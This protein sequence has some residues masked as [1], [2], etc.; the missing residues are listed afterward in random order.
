[1]VS[2]ELFFTNNVAFRND[3][4]EVLGAVGIRKRGLDRTRL[5]TCQ[6]PYLSSHCFATAL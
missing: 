2:I 3:I 4:N 5:Y 6:T 1:V